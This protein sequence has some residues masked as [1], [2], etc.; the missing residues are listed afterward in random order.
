M[1]KK[2]RDKI[3]AILGKRTGINCSKD[4]IEAVKNARRYEKEKH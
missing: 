4:F 1:V 3:K 2:A